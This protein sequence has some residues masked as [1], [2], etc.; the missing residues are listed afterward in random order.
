[1][2]ED[3]AAEFAEYVTARQQALRRAAYLLCRDVDRVEDLVQTAIT[4]LFVSWRRA[5]RADDLDA[6]AHTVLVRVFLDE[7]RRGWWRMRSLEA[8]P[9]LAAPVVDSDTRLTVEEALA[10]L[11]PRQRAVV[12]LR[13]YRDLDVEQTAQA[14]GCSAG[15]VKSQTHRALGV[16]RAA[17][18][19]DRAGHLPALVNARRGE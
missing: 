18:G 8:S 6:Y 11:T 2:G 12:V 13:F 19:G 9:E 3:H 15:T 16:L 14:L 4:K 10:A 17:L 1:V 7:Q 5:R